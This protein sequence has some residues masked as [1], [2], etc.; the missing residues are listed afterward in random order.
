MSGVAKD[1]TK[2]GGKTVTKL[3]T[4]EGR[5]SR[6]F[7]LVSL[8]TGFKN[9]LK[10]AGYFMGAALVSVNYYLSLGVL[11]GFIVAAYPFAI[12]GLSNEL[13]RARKEN[14][15]FSHRTLG[16]AGSPS[17]AC[18]CSEAGTCGSR[19]RSPSSSGIQRLVSGGVGRL[20]EPSWLFSSSCTDRCRAGR[21]SWCCGPCDSRLPTSTL[22]SGGAARCL[23]PRQYLVDCSSVQACLGSVPAPQGPSRR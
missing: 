6:L 15:K 19:S 14:V 16:S 18:S 8:I 1:L 22:H 13:G 5:N 4:P 9:S 17:R 12:F 2:L 23:S 21:P 7:K 10:G 11:C 20:P 3:V